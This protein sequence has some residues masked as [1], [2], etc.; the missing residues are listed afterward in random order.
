MKSLA[1]FKLKMWIIQ[2]EIVQIQSDQWN[3]FSTNPDPKGQNKY[4][5]KHEYGVLKRNP[6]ASSTPSFKPLPQNLHGQIGSFSSN[7]ESFPIGETIGNKFDELEK[8][9]LSLESTLDAK[10][11]QHASPELLTT[12]RSFNPFSPQRN[13]AFN[14]Q[15]EAQ[16]DDQNRVETFGR[17]HSKEKRD[18]SPKYI[19]SSTEHN[20][21]RERDYD[22]YYMSRIKLLE[23]KLNQAQYK[24]AEYEAELDKKNS[25]LDD[26]TNDNSRKNYNYEQ[27][28]YKL[29]K[30]E[31]A[32]ERLKT[33]YDVLREQEIQRVKNDLKTNEEKQRTIDNLSQQI[34][35]KESRISELENTISQQNQQLSEHK[36]EVERL[37]IDKEALSKIADTSNLEEKIKNLE[38][39]VNYYRNLI[40]NERRSRQVLG[41]TI[42]KKESHLDELER[43]NYRLVS[44]LESKEKEIQRRI[45]EINQLNY[46]LTD[47]N[48]ENS[49][50]QLELQDQSDRI[51]EL[52]AD[53]AQC[54]KWYQSLEKEISVF[55]AKEF[56]RLGTHKQI[57]EYEQKIRNL[58]YEKEVL[59][60]EHKRAR[61]LENE[62]NYIKNSQDM[63]MSEL[64][65][66][67]SQ[68]M[69]ELKAMREEN[70]YLKENEEKL[71]TKIKQISK[72]RD[73]LLIEFNSKENIDTNVYNQKLLD[74][75]SKINT[76]VNKSVTDLKDDVLRKS[77]QEQ[78]IKNQK[79]QMIYELQEKIRKFKDDYNRKKAS[80]EY[81]INE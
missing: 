34:V 13:E 43:S 14:I 10:P 37:Q 33:T 75:E 51:K 53:L 41:D 11:E 77:I 66:K 4:E 27:L 2:W 65:D 18:R 24:I 22:K 5:S 19:D 64:E 70:E 69:D 78:E 48:K 71:K 8:R 47:S 44:D 40:D 1:K 39:D 56:D 12:L 58:E 28:Y 3:I 20:N 63:Q 68:I 79:S 81:F 38:N 15:D 57:A 59:E 74:I 73:E 50:L 45:D 80:K 31:K 9:L 26:A 6:Q 35:D 17:S 60:E 61:E 25:E 49:D 67:F 16:I 32:N 76:L 46:R 72:E 7:G 36:M 21:S 62:L 42:S 55:K 54:G 23:D 29:E 30:A 52:E